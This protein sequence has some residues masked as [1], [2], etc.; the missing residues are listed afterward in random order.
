MVWFTQWPNMAVRVKSPILFNPVT[1]LRKDLRGINKGKK[2]T[3]Y[4]ARPH[5]REKK[6]SEKNEAEEKLT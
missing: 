3:P 1:H 4:S 2:I 5:I 6:A